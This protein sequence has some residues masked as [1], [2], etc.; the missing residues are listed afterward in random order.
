M[1]SIAFII[2]NRPAQTARVFEAIRAAQ[3][4]QLFIIA[5]GPRPHKAGEAER[6]AATRA[7][8]NQIDWACEIHR[9]YSDVNLGCRQR[10][11]S[12]IS[13]VFEQVEDAIILEDDCLPHPTF[14]PFCKALLDRYRHDQRVTS[15]SGNNF[16]FGNQRT[17]YSYYFSRYTHIWGW[18]TWRRAWSGFDPQLAYWPRVQTSGVIKNLFAEPELA[19]FWA[20]RF[21]SILTGRDTWD[22]QWQ[23]HTWLQGGLNVL[24]NVNLV[25][26][27]GFGADA[28]HTHAVNRLADIPLAALDFPLRHPPYLIRDALADQA[29]DGI[30][31]GYTHR[32]KKNLQFWRNKLQSLIANH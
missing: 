12:G 21:Q 24:P 3:P 14:F 30:V 9:N 32:P 31:Y 13:W 8:T 29:T 23:L 15:I 17:A 26:N 11:S 22:Y 18:A 20:A 19:D 1:S 7:I 2:F 25:T 28:T 4:R 10:V 5:D 6:C 27:I 16:Q